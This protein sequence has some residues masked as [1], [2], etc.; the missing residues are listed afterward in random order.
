[1]FWPE[2]LI[3]SPTQQRKYLYKGKYFGQRPLFLLL[4]VLIYSLLLVIDNNQNLISVGLKRQNFWISGRET[5]LNGKKTGKN[6]PNPPITGTFEVF[7]CHLPSYFF[8]VFWKAYFSPPPGLALLAK[9][10]IHVS[11][12]LPHFLPLKTAKVTKFG[13]TWR[14]A[15]KNVNM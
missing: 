8:P 9:I 2:N 11:L 1:M 13:L 4:P 14:E 5:I 7:L 15:P 6:R 12:S 10:S 3:P